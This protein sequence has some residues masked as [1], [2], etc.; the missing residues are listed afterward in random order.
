M[1]TRCA[2]LAELA[3]ATVSKTVVRKDV[4]VRVP[5]SAPRSDGI[6]E[7]GRFP[8]VSRSPRWVRGCSHAG[9][10]FLPHRV[11]ILRDQVTGR[12]RSRAFSDERHRRVDPCGRPEPRS[13]AYRRRRGAISPAAGHP[14]PVRWRA[15]LPPPHITHVLR[16]RGG[17]SGLDEHHLVVARTGLV[18][19]VPGPPDPRG[20]PSAAR[21][22]AGT[23][24][25]RARYREAGSDPWPDRGRRP[26]AV[27]NAGFGPVGAQDEREFVIG[28]G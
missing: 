22:W 16:Y 24:A 19:R 6:S 27:E 21:R 10:H 2:E 14:Q 26:A 3:D 5:H 23:R 20:G 11:R 15:R 17:R 4:W 28:C 18:D 1:C 8:S 12:P 7:S 25:R 9:V 13:P